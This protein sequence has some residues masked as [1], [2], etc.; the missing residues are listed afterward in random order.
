MRVKIEGT[1]KDDTLYEAL[2]YLCTR[3]AEKADI[4]IMQ[5]RRSKSHV[6]H[7]NTAFVKVN[8]LKQLSSTCKHDAVR[9]EVN[10]CVGVSFYTGF[11][12]VTYFSSKAYAQNKETALQQVCSNLYEQLE[13]SK[14]FDIEYWK[15]EHLLKQL[16]SAQLS[17]AKQ[18]RCLKLYS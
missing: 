3:Y 6:S 13:V 5:Y 17:K 14:N 1:Y 15:K 8:S 11:E 2:E 18:Q 7:Y 12:A 9:I 10:V 4:D 16:R